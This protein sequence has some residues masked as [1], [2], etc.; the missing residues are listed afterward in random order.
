MLRAVV[1]GL[2]SSSKH[3]WIRC[4]FIHFAS[5]DYQ[6][7]RRKKKGDDQ[8]IELN[9][10]QY[11]LEY[12][13]LV[14]CVC[15]VTIWFDLFISNKW[16]W[17]SCVVN[18]CTLCVQMFCKYDYREHHDH[19]HYR[20]RQWWRPEWMVQLISILSKKTSVKPNEQEQIKAT[21]RSVRMFDLLLFPCRN[22]CSSTNRI[23]GKFH[24]IWIPIAS[25]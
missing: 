3:R 25:S 16:I 21:I 24:S 1:C 11:C 20:W 2:R 4:W 5:I 18:K 9:A 19:H 8:V 14:V 23:R 6:V 17:W 22:F 15:F 13:V 10:V 12:F 7:K